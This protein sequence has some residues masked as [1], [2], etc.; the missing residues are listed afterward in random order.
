MKKD[1]LK[2][3]RDGEPLTRKQLCIL[4][5][6]LSVPA[7]LAQI[8]SI[9]MQYID[10]SMVG[11]LGSQESA[12]IGLMASSTWL[13][14]GLCMASGIGFNV[15]IAQAIGA[16]NDVK[17]RQIVRL[18]IVVSLIFSVLLLVV[19][20]WIC[21]SLPGW[22][23][24]ESALHADASAYFFIFSLFMP[25]MTLNYVC[26]GMLQSSGNMKTP[27]ILHI[28]MCVLDVIFNAV[29]IF[30][31]W[32]VEI[33][34]WTI[35]IPGF[36][37]GVVGAAL[38]TALAECVIVLLMLYFLLVRSPS[39]RLRHGERFESCNRLP[40][41][42]KALKIAAP[43]GFEQ[44][45]MCGAQIAST[46]IVAPLGMASIAANSFSITA[47]SLCY[48]PGY[49]IGVAATTLIGQSIGAKRDD[50]TRK[51]GWLTTAL[52]MGVMAFT[53][54]L[55]FV[56]APQMIA[57][58]SPDPEIQALG[59]T[60]LRI[61]AFAEPMYAASIVATGVFRGAGDTLVPSCMNFVSMW[62][63]R[64]PLA[65]L[66]ARNLGLEGVWIAMCIELCCRGA[67][68]LMR[69]RGRKW[70]SAAGRRKDDDSESKIE[71]ADINQGE[72]DNYED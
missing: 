6:Q 72:M 25:V 10:A 52:G 65:A 57:L 17:A 47:E 28:A 11:H 22:L 31:D 38:G 58:L 39:L 69:M 13:F 8:S 43:I 62:F 55:M 30:P 70:Q 27:A 19:G 41:L 7:I 46:R 53:G 40:I 14:G 33:A 63:I 36:G 71:N 56:F 61:E 1:Y 45:V 49:G 54:A 34:D 9:V 32:T 12:S 3:L 64:L 59:T 23:G 20:V 68:F 37:L 26:G 16:K 42:K 60:I 24:S 48:M 51:L 66:L 44:A 67:M 50:L 4:I 35:A 5:L 29:L 21:G 15:Q 2:Q 18:G